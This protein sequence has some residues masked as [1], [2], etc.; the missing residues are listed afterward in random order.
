M[1]YAIGSLSVEGEIEGSTQLG[2]TSNS[3]GRQI[4]FGVCKLLSPFYLQIWGDSSPI[5]VFDEEG[6]GDAMGS[7]SVAGIPVVEGCPMRC[8]DADLPGF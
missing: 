6:C 8:A 3:E 5:N 4:V 7:S 2:E 1:G